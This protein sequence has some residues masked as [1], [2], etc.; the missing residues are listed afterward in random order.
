MREIP[1][2]ELK[3]NNTNRRNTEFVD[4]VIVSIR[5]LG[6]NVISINIKKTDLLS[7]EIFNLYIAIKKL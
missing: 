5:K 7:I 2:F 6:N 4:T 1:F 3:N